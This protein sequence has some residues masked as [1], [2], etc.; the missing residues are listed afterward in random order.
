MFGEEAILVGLV[1]ALSLDRSKVPTESAEEVKQRLKRVMTGIEDPTNMHQVP[2]CQPEDTWLKQ[3]VKPNTQGVWDPDRVEDQP[4]IVQ[5]RNRTNKFDPIFGEGYGQNTWKF[6]PE[7]ETDPDCIEVE[8]HETDKPA[9]TD[10]T[11]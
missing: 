5:G 9:D 8:A 4:N 3:N 2:G 1:A 10:F 7:P 6:D 11:K